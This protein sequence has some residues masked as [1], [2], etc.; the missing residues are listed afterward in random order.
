MA[1]VRLP[2]AR[3]RQRPNGDGF[4]PRPMIRIKRGRLRK[5]GA[6]GKTQAGETAAPRLPAAPNISPHREAG[7][8]STARPQPRRCR[9]SAASRWRGAWARPIPRERKRAATPGNYRSAPFSDCGTTSGPILFRLMST[10]RQSVSVTR[11]TGISTIHKGVIIPHPTI[12]ENREG[13]S[14]SQLPPPVRMHN[15]SIDIAG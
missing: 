15:T 10:G 4:A 8:G 7:A 14:L 9:A 13:A 6:G 11:D 2:P 3:E 1:A 5:G 12:R